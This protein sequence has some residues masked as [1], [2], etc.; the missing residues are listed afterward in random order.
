MTAFHILSFGT[1]N[2][3]TTF[4]STKGNGT[5]GLF[6]QDVGSNNSLTVDDGAYLYDLNGVTVILGQDT[7]HGR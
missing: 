7:A 2:N 5:S 3:T 6:N 1:P 4:S